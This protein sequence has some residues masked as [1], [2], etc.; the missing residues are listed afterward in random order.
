[1]LLR[2]KMA[3]EVDKPLSLYMPSLLLRN[4]NFIRGKIVPFLEL[5]PD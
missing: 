1:M 3:Y 2:E 5:L 4:N